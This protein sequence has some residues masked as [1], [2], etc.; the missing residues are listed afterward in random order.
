MSG[1]R[2]SPVPPEKLLVFRRHERARIKRL[3]FIGRKNAATMDDLKT[4][5]EIDREFFE[6]LE[7]D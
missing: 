4:F 1:V 2:A 7:D 6:A 3:L 5:E